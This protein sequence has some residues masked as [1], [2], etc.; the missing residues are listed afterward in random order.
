MYFMKINL[1]TILLLLSIFYLQG[2]I[3]DVVDNTFYCEEEGIFFGDAL[4][5]ETTNEFWSYAPNQKLI[6]KTSQGNELTLFQEDYDSLTEFMILQ[7]VCGGSQLPAHEFHS[8]NAEHRNVHFSDSSG[9]INIFMSLRISPWY[10]IEDELNY[11]EVLNVYGTNNYMYFATDKV[12]D[13]AVPDY[14][15]IGNYEQVDTTLNGK[16]FEN[17]Y[18][19]PEYIYGGFYS[20]TQGLVAFY[21]DQL[22]FYVLDRIE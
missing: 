20:K 9:S 3:N 4:F 21:D 12:G 14:L 7:T 17:V 8:I 5:S 15:W 16:T 6:F 22:N 13:I 10:E 18:Y 1:T 19:R 2:C 11:F